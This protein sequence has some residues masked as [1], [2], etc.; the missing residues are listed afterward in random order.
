MTRV[1]FQ[2]LPRSDRVVAACVVMLFATAARAATGAGDV[3][4]FESKI[5][6]VL[7]Q[8]CYECH[9]AAGKKK[10]GLL[11]DSRAGWQAGGE[12]GPVIV[13]GD[14]SKSLFMQAI[15]HEKEDLKMPKAGAKLTEAA[16]ADFA[17]W[18]NSGAP[19]P[20]DKPPSRE[21]LARAT[22]WRTVLARRKAEGWAFQPVGNPPVPELRG[23]RREEARIHSPSGVAIAQ[24][25]VPPHVVSYEHPID[26]FI[27]KKIED[28]GLRQAQQADAA[29]VLRRLTFV[30]TGLPPKFEDVAP[31]ELAFARDPGAAVAATADA[32]LASPR[33]GEKWARHWMDWVRYAESY[34]SEGDPAIP[35]AW[36][37]R[38]YLIRAF[39]DDV[40]YP[41]MVREA[42]A[43]DLL[44]RP[45]I[46]RELGTNESALGIGQLRM[47]LH[48]FSPVD[49]LDEMVTFTDNQI[50]V[51][52]KA[53]L[54]LTVSCARCHNHKFDPI[55]QT[56]FYA[57]FGIFGSTRPAVIDVSLENR[58]GEVRANLIGLKGRIKEA[59]GNAWLEAAR[60]MARPLSS[61]AGYKVEPRSNGDAWVLKRWDLSREKWFADGAGVRQGATKPGEFSIAAEGEKII[62]HIHPGG[63][64]TDLVSAKDRGVLMSPRFKNEGGTL[65]VRGA[66]GGGARARYIVDNYPRTGTIHKAKDFKDA[67]DG[68]LSWH[69]LD[70]E[71][72]KGDEIFIQATTA[73]DM[74]VET[75]LDERSWFGI[76]EVVISKG[77]EPPSRPTPSGDPLEAVKAWLAGSATNEQA[78][79][80]DALLRQGKL[81]ND[82]GLLPE[83][84]ARVAEYRKLEEK[85]P[86]PVRAPGVLEADAGDARLFTQ[87]DHK[88]PA[89]TV[90]RR[91]LEGIDARPY[92]ARNDGT[93]A[94]A[95]RAANDDKSIVIPEN[96]GR[97][98][99][100]ESMVRSDN[101]L[102]SRVIV[103]RIWHHVFGR[104]IVASTDNF[105]RL[106]E[107]P[108]H[109]E[110]LDHLASRFTA[111][112]GSL[113]SLIRLLVTSEA[114]RMNSHAPPGAAE[115]D[116]DN[117]L[118]THFP[119][120]RIEA[121]AIRDSML[122]VS[123]ALDP[124]MYGE[125]V[126]GGDPR[127]SI[128]V[129][130]I[131]NSLDPLLTVFDA[132]VPSSTRGRRDSTNVPAQSLT[133]LNDPNVGRWADGWAQRIVAD[134][135]LADD[136]ARLRRMFAGALGRS[137]SDDELRGGLAFV[138][139]IEASGDVVKRELTQAE[140]MAQD[141]QRRIDVVLGP[142]RERLERDAKSRAGDGADVKRVPEPFAEWD[143]KRG[144]E[145]LRGRLNL[146]LQGDARIENGALVLDG[147]R[148]YAKSTVLTK[149]LREKTME[150]WVMLENL[151][152]RGG[153]VMTLQDDRGDVF[154]SIVFA[155][156]RAG[157]WVPG[158]D[159][160]RRS[161]NLDAPAE[162]EAAT[163]MVH[164]AIVYESNGKVA[165][166][167]DGRRLGA[168]YQSEGPAKFESGRSE[169]LFGLRHGTSAG[170]NRVLQG[171]IYR[172]RLY[173]RALSAEEIAA[174]S[175][176]EGTVVTEG[177]VLA[178]LSAAERDRVAGLRARSA[179]AQKHLQ[180]LRDIER[181]GG[182]DFGWKCL[183]QSLFNLKEFIYLR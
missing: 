160:F 24:K 53:F 61:D 72:W 165:A 18:I 82:A 51:V 47:V 142:A 68:T 60:K 129:R 116:P 137:P 123:G 103:N 77:D 36:R 13:P 12:S 179:E 78:E 35:Y 19:D 162:T 3:E 136:A 56:D 27:L 120:R 76:T 31:F 28:A 32:L 152:Q 130:V 1:F 9:S 135:S 94:V 26:R 102:A 34:G 21:E 140:G 154:D 99:L 7:A 118:L 147:G 14:A 156:K 83:A 167:R 149:T 91:F 150:A 172:A 5:R 157:C 81:P 122:A 145:D 67:G 168:P 58:G 85:L 87:G 159:Y 125:S 174:S 23:S 66:G 131:R 44:A 96:S 144:R 79:L 166:Y 111:Q 73:A 121:E 117:K 88:R 17:K 10:G 40:P 54:G 106:G 177:E 46:N 110:L 146:I 92:F 39:N 124:A 2:I 143:F 163:R 33:F 43:G 171:R 183:A 134:A 100:A 169:I 158:S 104:G 141:L 4:F 70:L 42:I 41:Q 57:L 8:D 16:I 37:Y 151:D 20:R 6:P 25:S 55:S 126:G 105:G 161:R 52:S 93:P 95:V 164:V 80:L 175:R 30:L 15:R 114:F 112:G 62:A 109:P 86:V 138:K 50:D 113:K 155:E 127:R 119:V 63:I 128:Y 84:A 59:V 74:A 97:L 98:Q 90:P 180:E 65:W 108:T 45:R 29:T 133:L 48:G 75:K 153:G 182:P 173:D 69:K 101:P 170:G 148:S 176:L 22:D 132:P 64:F 38:D 139:A 115:K 71:Y 178:S 181:G 11:L 107:A 49:S 89:D